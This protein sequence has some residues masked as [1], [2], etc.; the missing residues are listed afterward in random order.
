MKKR[1]TL[2]LFFLIITSTLLSQT[3]FTKI[4]SGPPVED[5]GKSY[6]NSFIDANGDGHED[7]FI[8]NGYEDQPNVLYINQGDGTFLVDEGI[9]SDEAAQSLG[10]S[11]GDYDNDGDLDLYVANVGME[12]NSNYFYTNNG[13]GSFTKETTGVIV[14]DSHWSISCSWVDYDN[15]SWLDLFVANFDSPNDLYHNNGD[16]TFTAVTTGEIVMENFASFGHAWAD[17]DND[18]WQD[19]F[20]ANNY[21]DTL[22]AHNNSLFHNNGDGTFTKIT[23]GEIVNDNAESHGVSWGDYNNDGWIDLFVTNHDWNINQKNFLYK[24]NGDGSF[25]KVLDPELEADENT[26]FG[27]TWLDVD[28][29]GYLDLYYSNN[30]SGLRE[31]GLFINNGDNTFTRDISDPSTLDAFRSHGCASGDTNNDGRPDLFSASFSTS[32][33]N[34]FYLNN[35]S[36]NNW[37]TLELIGTESNLS[38]IGARIELISGGLLQSRQVS[39]QTGFYSQNSFKQ[40]FGIGSETS[41]SSIVIYWPSGIIQDVSDLEVNQ[42][43][44]ITEAQDMEELNPPTNLAVTDLGHLTWDAPENRDFIEYKI[45]LDSAEQATTTA[46]N[47]QLNDLVNNTEYTAE[48]SAIYD[49]GESELLAVTFVAI[50][51]ATEENEISS[52]QNRLSSYPNPFYLSGPARSGSSKIVFTLPENEPGSLRIY[53]SKGQLVYD[54]G[55]FEAGKHTVS[56]HGKDENDKSVSSGNYYYQLK[57]KQQHQIKKISVIK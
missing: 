16:G 33:F 19:L 18:G 27:S 55:S 26:S 5:P 7:I 40:F 35:G 17:Y 9:L 1:K 12:N 22:P 25:T 32:H 46:T 42:I 51:T 20:I 49:G 13:D 29:D 57:T 10:S 36:E 14:T 44:T 4:D 56:W 38:A 3:Y 15:D 53:N 41:I 47:Y 54:F 45:Y 34:G 30:R 39:A 28:S 23:D 8:C 48:V 50:L 2:A 31:N 37:I 11:W 24:N 43:H 52:L 21:Y 6:G